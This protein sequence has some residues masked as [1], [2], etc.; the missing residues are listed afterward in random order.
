MCW[1]QARWEF[2]V[3]HPISWK[4]IYIYRCI[5]LAYTSRTSWI[6][7]I[8]PIFWAID[9]KEMTMAHMKIW[10]NHPQ[11]D[12][13]R[14]LWLEKHGDIGILPMKMWGAKP[15]IVGIQLEIYEDIRGYLRIHQFD[16]RQKLDHPKQQFI[17]ESWWN[18]PKELW[19]IYEY[20]MNYLHYLWE[21]SKQVFVQDP[22]VARGTLDP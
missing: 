5:Y 19:N 3:I 8:I 4:A 13:E 22:N 17:W 2:M 18:S 11:M 16:I 7:R 1:C 21:V 10:R 12:I 20:L 15:I 6:D 14:S 9:Q